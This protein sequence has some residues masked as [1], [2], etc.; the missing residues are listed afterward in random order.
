MQNT[1]RRRLK[2]KLRRHSTPA[3]LQQKL[4]IAF[5]PKAALEALNEAGYESRLAG[6]CVRDFLLG[7]VPGDFDLATTATPQEVIQLFQR[8]NF[9]WVEGVFP[10]GV[11]HG[12]VTVVTLATKIEI[13]TLRED[14]NTDGRHAEVIFGHS[15]EEDAKRRDFT[16]NALFQDLDG[17]VWDYV[18][19]VKDI[20]ARTLRF[21][22]DPRRRIREDYLRSLRFFRFW[23]ALAKFKVDRKSL[24]ACYAETKGLKSLSR[25]RINDELRKMFAGKNLKAVLPKFLDPKLVLEIFPDLDK[26]NL[27]KISK[28]ILS[29]TPE[30]RLEGWFAILAWAAKTSRNLAEHH[31]VSAEIELTSKTVLDFL[32]LE[33]MSKGK[34]RQVEYLESSFR[35]SQRCGE[36]TWRKAVVIGNAIAKILL[37]TAVNK[38]C[39]ELARFESKYGKLRI[40]KFPFD[41]ASV[42]KKYKLPSGP[43]V[44]LYLDQERRDFWRKKI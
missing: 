2:Q 36:E 26:N 18:G 24:A 12:T 7:K 11:A 34:E 27:R 20:K 35:I 15:F 17:K 40:A 13:T 8:E 23:S 1:Q 9:R 37:P 43:E 10:T 41:G 33:L 30:I 19:G 39:S 42:M 4:Q 44:G 6:G 28:I 38:R 22:G 32:H 29:L 21:V 3:G 14:V 25:E 5:E 16:V 31:R